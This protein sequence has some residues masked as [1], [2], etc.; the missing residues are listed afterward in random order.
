M[1]TNGPLALIF[2]ALFV[3][4]ILAPLV[5][6][7]VV[8]FTDK[9]YLSLP[10]DGLSLRWFRAILENPD[11][12]DSFWI[13]LYLALGSATIALAVAIPAPFVRPILARYARRWP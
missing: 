5:V 10:T 3:T 4:F 12:I 1:K 11:F 13:S 8:A 9:G 2:H 6:V 7:C